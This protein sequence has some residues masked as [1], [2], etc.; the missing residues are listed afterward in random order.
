MRAVPR[1]V[2]ALDVAWPDAG[3]LRIIVVHG[4]CR[5]R[6]ACGNRSIFRSPLPVVPLPDESAPVL[7]IQ[8]NSLTA[9]FERSFLVTIDRSG[10]QVQTVSVSRRKLDR[11][12]VAADLGEAQRP[13][14]GRLD[15]RFGDRR[16]AGGGAGA[17][18]TKARPLRMMLLAYWLASF[19]TSTSD[20]IFSG[21]PCSM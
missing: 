1:Q 3:H 17:A 16:V 10:Q 11:L 15:C 12:L 8:L 13:E 21:W 20:G 9:C 18:S 2:R 14:R 7:N 19:S 6:T 4:S 5:P